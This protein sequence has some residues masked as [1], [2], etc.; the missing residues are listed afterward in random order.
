M[1]ALSYEMSQRL[2]PE[3]ALV[4]CCDPGTVNTKMLLSG[5]G[6][7]GIEVEDATDEYNLATSEFDPSAQGNYYVGCRKS[8]CSA[9]VYDAHSRRE[10]WSQVE[11][12]SGVVWNS[13][14]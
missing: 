14:L 6:R 10:L 5:W 7:C 13:L 2:R 3:D 12:L 8:T 4:L 1:A 9:D 11:K